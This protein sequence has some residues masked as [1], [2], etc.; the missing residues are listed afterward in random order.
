MR[1]IREVLRL[2]LELGI[3][4][5][6]VGR[7]C[8]LG[9]ATVSDYGSRAKA[10]GLVWP[11]KEEVTDAALEALL[12]PPPPPKDTDRPVPQWEHVRSELARK[13]VTLA[14]VWQEYKRK[15]PNG[16][17][18]SY[19]AELYRAWEGTHSYSMIQLHRPGEKLFVDFAGMTM[20]LKDGKTGEFTQVQIFVA[21]T[22]Y[23][24]FIYVRACMSQNLTDWLNSHVLAF[25][26]FGGTPE[27]VVPDNLKS[28]VKTP[29]RYDPEQNPAYAELARHYGVVVLHARG[30]KPKD[31]AK[32]ENGVQQVERWVLAPLRDRVFFSLEEMQGAI[33][34]LVKELNEKKLTDV[35]FS[36]RELFEA[37]E[38]PKLRPLP[39]SRYEFAEWRKAK[40]APD[41]HVRF[42][43]HAYSVPHRLCGKTVDIR[44]TTFRVEVYLEGV[45]VAGHERGIG[46]RHLSTVKEHMPES[47]REYAEWTPERLTRWASEFGP[48]TGEF[49]KVSLARYEQPEHGFRSAFGIVSLSKKYGEKRLEKACAR[50]LRAGATRYQNVK[51]ILEKGLDQLDDPPPE[52]LALVFHENVRGAVYF[53]SE[54]N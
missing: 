20:P 16:Y 11:P 19:F 35:P 8:G 51:S 2:R 45:L 30:R 4:A 40:V 6:D 46:I 32:V 44:L 47:H 43:S 13:G 18:Y 28:G 41:Y 5:R 23:S 33:D 36:R 22:G 21:A 24:Q 25:E 9:S 52:G 12:F 38:K 50:A 14:L 53:G 54:L 26:F 39:A 27:V 37:E 49:V 17:N 7:S 10:A 34:L 31:K 3:S 42:E 1:K 48:C 15:D 29:C